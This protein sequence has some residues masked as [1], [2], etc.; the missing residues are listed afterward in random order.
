MKYCVRISCIQYGNAYVEAE[1]PD[2]AKKKA[3]EI[4]NRR[5]IDWFDEEITDMTVEE[6]TE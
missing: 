6:E 1:H 5:G 4:Y 2:E 3:T